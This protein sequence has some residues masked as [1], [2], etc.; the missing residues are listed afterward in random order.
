MVAEGVVLFRVEHL[1]QG[2]RRVTAEVR[3]EFVNLIQDEDGVLGFHAAK[4]LNNLARQRPD[5]RPAV[6]TDFGLVSHPSQ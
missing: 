4:T 6:A 1:K 2:G 3:A 5:I